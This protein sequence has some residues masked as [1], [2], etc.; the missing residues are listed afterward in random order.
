MYINNEDL[1]FLVHLENR[2]GSMENWSEDVTRLWELIEKLQTQRKIQNEKT[3]R[4]VTEKR[5]ADPLYARSK[6]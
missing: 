2:L 6:K 5:K 3:L 1:E 4:A